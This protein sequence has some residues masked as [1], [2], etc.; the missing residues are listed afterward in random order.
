VT[1]VTGAMLFRAVDQGPASLGKKRHSGKRKEAAR[2]RGCGCA[3]SWF[4]KAYLSDFPDPGSDCGHW[5]RFFFD[6][7]LPWRQS[8]SV[9][10]GGPLPEG[11]HRV[12]RQALFH[13]LAGYT[14]AVR[15]DFCAA[16][17]QRKA[18]GRF[19]ATGG[20]PT[21]AH[22]VRATAII[23]SRPASPSRLRGHRRSG[24][25]LPAW[26]ARKSDLRE[27]AT[28]IGKDRETGR[29]CRSRN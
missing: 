22:T 14:A 23:G 28:A 16:V 9:R 6:E 21:A 15:P 2:G 12:L 5:V 3:A 8:A 19:R 24:R 26:A 25:R 13:F 10:G 29:R 18:R 1:A 20:M 11:L 17:S 27:S 7:I 4:N